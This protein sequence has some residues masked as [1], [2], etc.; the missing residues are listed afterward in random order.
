MSTGK[1]STR[2]YRP[3]VTNKTSEGELFD[4]FCR[5]LRPLNDGHVEL[6]ANN[7]ERKRD[8]SAQRKSPDFIR[9]SKNGSSNSYSKRRRNACRLGFGKPTK[10]EAW[11]LRYC[12]SREFGYLRILE[13]EGVEKRRLT[14]ALDGIARDF[15]P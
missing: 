2:T 6:K 1:G 5:M 9:N 13:L 10:T 7:G 3:K 15:G 8:T 4:I 14:A 12:R 11:M